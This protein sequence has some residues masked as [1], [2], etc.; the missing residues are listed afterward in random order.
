MERED[1]V[2]FSGRN[3][4]EEKRGPNRERGGEKKT[5]CSLRL[6]HDDSSPSHRWTDRP[7]EKDTAERQKK[8]SWGLRE[9][10][11]RV[12]DGGGETWEGKGAIISSEAWT[13]SASL[14]SCRAALRRRPT[15][16]HEGQSYCSLHR[17]G[18]SES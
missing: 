13:A 9:D 11:M 5:Q 17:C 14:G 15:G 3:G 7:R 12:K 1:D 4:G 6:F 2:I 8:K 10:K 16:R 18:V